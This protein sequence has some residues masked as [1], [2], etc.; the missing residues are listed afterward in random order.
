ME[1]VSHVATIVA[2]AVKDLHVLVQ[3]QP[4]VTNH[5]PFTF[6]SLMS[7][8]QAALYKIVVVLQKLNHTCTH[9]QHTVQHTTV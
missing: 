5:P 8:L 2:C 6:A 3:L 1:A 9:T 4:S 7:L